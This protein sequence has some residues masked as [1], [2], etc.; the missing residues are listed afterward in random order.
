MKEIPY[1]SAVGNLMYVKVCTTPYI[2]FVVGMLGRYQSNPDI[3]KEQ[4]TTFL[5]T[6]DQITWK[7]LPTLIQTLL[8]M[9]IHGN[10]LQDKYLC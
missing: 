5:C 8:V 7:S 10:Q 9:L 3:F 4:K 2:S 1:A 6:K